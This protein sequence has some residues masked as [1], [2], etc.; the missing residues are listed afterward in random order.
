MGSAFGTKGGRGSG[1]AAGALT[2]GIAR[3][4]RPPVR[5]REGTGGTC[6]GIARF[7][8]PPVGAPAPG[9]RSRD[10]SRAGFGS[11]GSSALSG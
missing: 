9:T 3:I 6:G 7:G 4:G 2:G 10:S 8:S 1:R 11:A 5:A